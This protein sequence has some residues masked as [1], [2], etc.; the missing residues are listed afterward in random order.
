MGCGSIG[1]FGFRYVSAGS[2]GGSIH[3]LGCLG[4]L[5]NNLLASSL[6]HLLSLFNGLGFDRGLLVYYLL[7]LD[8]LNLLLLV[9]LGGVDA[10]TRVAMTGFT[11]S[12][13]APT[14]VVLVHIKIDA[15]YGTEHLT[16]VLTLA[17]AT[18][19]G[20]SLGTDVTACATVLGVLES[21]GTTIRAAG[22]SSLARTHRIDALGGRGTESST[23][24]AVL[25]ILGQIVAI[26]A[27]LGELLGG[28]DALG[29]YTL[30]TP[31]ASVTAMAT[32]LDII[33]D[34]D[35]LAVAT[36]LAERTDATVATTRGAGRTSVEAFTTVFVV[37]L[38]RDADLLTLGMTTEVLGVGAHTLAILADTSITTFAIAGAAMVIVLLGVD[39]FATTGSLTCKTLAGTTLAILIL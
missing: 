1:C 23:A 5:A 2:Y 38:E 31:T 34:V 13:R 11:A 35:A 3:G 39:A 18:S 14:T 16:A 15:T 9:L 37:A 33:K 26:V 19:T 12:V 8:N 21:V 7:G 29:I 4:F 22:E 30:R 32:V 25:V 28:A 36:E 10:F 17:F 6:D 20:A 24:T 27:T